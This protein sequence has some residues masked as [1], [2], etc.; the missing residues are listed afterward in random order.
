MSSY[1]VV[2]S[3]L[4]PHSAPQV[5]AGQQAE[6]AEAEAVAA[7]GGAFGAKVEALIAR[8]LANRGQGGRSAAAPIGKG[9][10]G[11]TAATPVKSVVFSQ[12][13]GGCEESG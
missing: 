3:P 5:D 6:A 7:A 10:G 8:L 13:L 4:T 12:F 2:P 1:P 9:Q 11:C